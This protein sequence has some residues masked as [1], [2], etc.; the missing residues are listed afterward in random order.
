M[1]EWL[2]AVPE[3]VGTMTPLLVADGCMAPGAVELG[4]A[5][6][7]VEGCWAPVVA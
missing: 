5:E 3:A 6:L 7:W 2:G 1:E 4:A